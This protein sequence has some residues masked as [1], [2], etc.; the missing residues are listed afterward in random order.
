MF[1]SSCGASNLDGAQFCVKCGAPLGQAAPSQAPQSGSSTPLPAVGRKNIWVAA[2][3]NL[4][5]G[6][7]YLYLGYKK[8]LGMPTILFVIVI[9]L[10]DVIIGVFTF[11][12]VSFLI[13]V[14]LAYDGY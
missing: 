14:F 11:G 4:F 7:G 1:C 5:F 9:F 10:V 2:I 3:L 6:I 13:A 12:I 8:V